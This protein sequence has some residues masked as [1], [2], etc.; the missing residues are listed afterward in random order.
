MA[1][2]LLLSPYNKT[3]IYALGEKMGWNVQIAPGEAL[4]HGK[5]SYALKENNFTMVQSGKIDLSQGHATIDASL[6][7]SAMLYLE[8]TSPLGGRTFHAGAAIAPTQL[9]P[10]A[11]RPDDF[12]N[13]WANKIQSL[14]S[15]SVNPVL[16][17]ADSGDPN[18]DY[19]TLR[20]DN[21]NGSHVYG[22]LAKPKREG[23]FP[24]LVIFQWASPPYPLQRA[25]VTDHAKNGWLTLNI[26]PHDVLPTEKQSYYDAL[27]E[28]IKHYESIGNDDRDKSYFLRMY[29]GD[30]RAVEYIASRPD[31]DG[32]TLVVMGTSMGGQQSLCV[33]GLNSKITHV[34]VN[35]PAGCDTNGALHGRQEGYPNFPSDNPQVMKTALYF[36]PINFTSRIHATALV[37]MGFVDTTAPPA[38]IWTAFNQIPGPKQTT[39]MIDSPHNNL[40]TA[41]EQYPFNHTCAQW[42]DILVH[43]E[44]INPTPEILYVKAPPPFDDHQNMMDQLGIRSLRPG[45][46]AGDPAI[47]DETTA[48][49]YADSMPEVL[50]MKSGTKVTSADQ[51]PVRRAE[52]AEDF[53]REIY[54]RIPVN[55]PAVTWEVTQISHGQSGTIPT[56]TKTLI[57]H[58]DNSAH[59][60]LSVNIEASFT[61][62]ANAKKSVPVMISFAG[63]GPPRPGR[64]AF[65]FPPP[66]GVPWTQQAIEHG[67]GYGT[68]NPWSI[69]PDNNQLTTGI[70]GL[71]NR[72]KPRTPEQ[73]GALRAW[74]WGVSRLIDYFQDHPDAMVDPAKV[75]I[76]GVSRYGKA[77]LVTEAFE[78]RVA[79]ALVAS[80]GEGG[81]KI[82]RH[83]FG[84]GVENLAGGEYYWMAGNFIKYGAAD[85]SKTPADLPVDQHELIALCAP[86]PCFIS[87]GVPA[88]G[89][90]KWVDARGAFMAAVLASPVYELLGAHGLGISENYL[91]A[92]MPPIENLIGGLLA[93]RQHNGGHDVTPNWPAFFNW[94]GQYIS[95]PYL[96]SGTRDKAARDEGMRN[97]H[98]GSG[99]S[100]PLESNPSPDMQREGRG[101]S[102]VKIQ[103]STLTPV[104]RSDHNS[105]LAH[106]QLLAKARQGGID[107]Y[108]LG[109]SITRRWGCTDPQYAD[110]LANWKKNFFGY[111]A[112][113]FGW[114]GDQV[115][116][117][118]WRIDHGELDNV[119]P[120]VIVLLAG[121]NNLGG[122]MNDAKIADI[123]D[124]IENLI[125]V[126]RQK[127]PSASI[128]LTAI[129]PRNDHMDYLPAINQINAN[130]SAFAKSQGIYFININDKLA[131]S[132]GHLYPGMM[133]ADHLHPALPAYQI[134]ADA[135]KPVLT[136]LLGP[137]ATTDHAPPP[138]GDPSLAASR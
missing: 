117:V 93:W 53:E 92:E 43:G 57:G 23:K 41:E 22:Q 10:I 121:T 90:P 125:H 79:V 66:P 40:A 83:I 38:G 18:L 25:W 47:Y 31:W 77:A 69:Q 75:G 20:M 103:S 42:L 17:P 129:F 84:E 114:G 96:E 50:T 71:T 46:S 126:C 138:T 91:T 109:D 128:I 7:H 60:E 5:Y 76:E 21:I 131:D 67:W 78:P 112:A 29:L 32:K 35:E 24:A 132:D 97:A 81:A 56:I 30:Y 72:G 104:P 88:H 74:Q 106:E 87:Y 113:N 11:A 123:S 44:Q 94:V 52:I 73:W 15:I 130:L 49:R 86:R 119:K 51:W 12:D 37:S 133:N 64:P 36:D 101:F 98:T 16:T 118:L 135:L 80:S 95:S 89:D 127:A 54:G 134:W 55:V 1:Q 45:P 26:E 99:T 59:P 108:F 102:A 105:Q 39:P 100:V 8:I 116:N 122:E 107:L 9:Q 110:F 58:V 34:I 115:Q 28:R 120:K 65:H 3:G 111:N 48:N 19:A 62:P 27:P 68:I 61:V 124:G 136:K 6:D 137:P 82:F 14:Q 13:F 63:F 4:P 2:D 85:P 33:A 70:I